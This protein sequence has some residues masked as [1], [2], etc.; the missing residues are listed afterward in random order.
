M[1]RRRTTEK[2]V[3]VPPLRLVLAFVRKMRQVAVFCAVCASVSLLSVGIGAQATPATS[4][5]VELLPAPWLKLTGDVDSNSPAVWET[6]GDRRRLT[7]VTSWGGQPSTARGTQ[8]A[9]LG[10]PRPVVI[11]PWSGGGVWIEAVV[12]D[13]DGTWYGYYHEENIAAMC[14]SELVIPRIGAVRSRDGGRTWQPLGTILEAPPG[15]HDCGTSNEYFVGG[16]GDF[17]VQL[18]PESRDLYIFY[19]LYLSSQRRQGVGVARL[20]WADRDNPIGKAMVWRSRTWVPASVMA[21]PDES[22]RVIYPAAVPIFPTT[23][24]W[25]GGDGAVDA[26][27]GPSV[28]WNTHLGLYVMLL[29]RAQDKGFQQEGVYISY[30][31][32]LEDPRLWSAPTKIL[33]LGDWYPQV[34]GLEQDGTDKVAGEVARLFMSGSSSHYIRFTR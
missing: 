1:G 34:M 15:T 8:L 18:D 33:G 27:W 31:P 28:H 26:F 16:V 5:G 20:T 4:P 22:P 9:R 7:V 6:V 3:N 30:A 12:T 21:R 23:Q 14:G 17:S 11:E 2:G 13:V 29:N 32:R 25:H 19:S 10:P 24:S